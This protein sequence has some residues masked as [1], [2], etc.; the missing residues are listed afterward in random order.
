MSGYIFICVYVHFVSNDSKM[1]SLVHACN[2]L[3]TH[4]HCALYYAFFLICI[5]TCI[6]TRIIRVILSRAL[7][8]NP[9][10]YLP[11]IV[12]YRSTSRELT[13]GPIII[14]Y[15][16]QVS[17]NQDNCIQATVL[18][19]IIIFLL[20]SIRGSKSFFNDPSNIT[21]DPI[22]NYMNVYMNDIIYI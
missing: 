21:I 14:I 12:Q 16:G 15:C 9:Y 17:P 5:Y 19:I 6:G 8:F 7:T 3:I 22:D 4:T 10:L 18:Q 1:Q 20:S 11:I 2:N 13:L